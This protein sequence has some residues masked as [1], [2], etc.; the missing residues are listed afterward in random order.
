MR[1]HE[2]VVALFRDGENIVFAS[3]L[4]GAAFA[5]AAF[6]LLRDPPLMARVSEGARRLYTHRAPELG[7]EIV[8]RFLAAT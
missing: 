2:T 6:G 4:S 7:S 5:E 3:D 1:A 8:D